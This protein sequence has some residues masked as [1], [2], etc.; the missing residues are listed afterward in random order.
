MVKLADLV[1]A[2]VGQVTVEQV[3]HPLQLLHKVT[4][5]EMV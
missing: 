5:V 1:V 4:L 3:I 2:V